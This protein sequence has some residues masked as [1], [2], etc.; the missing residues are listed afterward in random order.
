MLLP[1]L[2]TALV[3]LPLLLGLVGFAPTVGVYA[4]FAA[5]AGVAGREW[6][7]LCRWG[8]RPGVGFA[9]GGLV[10]GVLALAW[11]L[12]ARDQWLPWLLGLAALHWLAAV[13]WLRAGPTRLA[14]LA[15]SPLSALQG[16]LVLSTTMLACAHLHAQPEGALKLLFAFFLV[17]AADIGAYLAGRNLGRRKLAPAI[18]PGKTLEGALGGLLLCGLWALTAGVWVFAVHGWAAIGL[19]VLCLLVAAGSVVGD[20]LESGFKRAAGVKDSGHLLPGHGGVLDRVDSVVAAVPLFTFGL[21]LMG[22][23]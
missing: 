22:L 10:V 3:L 1:R 14:A 5:V 2:L 15:N 20:L 8:R 16:L 21:M 17:F 23:A 19:V 13:V 12:P 6:A 9:Y 18:S 11:V 7:A 4:A